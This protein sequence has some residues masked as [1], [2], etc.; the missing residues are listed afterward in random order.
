MKKIDFV[1]FPDFYGIINMYNI[2]KMLS[3]MHIAKY[4]WETDKLKFF[5]EKHKLQT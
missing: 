1:C 4:S 5:L 2:Q 3:N